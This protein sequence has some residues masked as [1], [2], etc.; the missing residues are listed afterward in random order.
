MTDEAATRAATLRGSSAELRRR[1]EAAEAPPS[2]AAALRKSR[3]A[4]IAE[5][6]RSSPSRGVINATLDVGQQVRAYESGGASAISILTEPRRFGGSNEDL[7]KARAATALPLLKKDFHV[8]VAQIFEAKALGA[9]AALVIVRAVEPR[10]L[11]DLLDAG[12]DVGL[13]IL[14]EVRDEAELELALFYQADIIGVNN[15]NLE[16]LEIDPG[17]AARVIPFIPA[18]VTAVAESGVKTAEDV[19]RLADV[20]AD[21]VLVGS[22]LSGAADP[23]SAVRALADFKRVSGARKG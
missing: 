18:G 19:S 16:T 21:A 9:S 11:L 15:R 5:V 10:R 8:D 20:G 22:E 4:I 1:A 2:F 23:T 13:D 14:V 3:V 12:R 17:T 6:K 7:I